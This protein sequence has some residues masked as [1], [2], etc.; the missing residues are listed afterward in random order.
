L[1]FVG[2]FAV[3][4][5]ARA[6]AQAFDSETTEILANHHCDAAC[7]SCAALKPRWL[8]RGSVVYMDR[9]TD[10][11][12]ALMQN[13]A[14]LSQQLNADDFDFGWSVGLDVSLM[15]KRW[16]NNGFEFRYLDLGQ[17]DA[18]TF[19]ITN[20][21]SLMLNASPPVF[22][23]NVQSID[24]RYT[25]DL[26]SFEANYH[27]WIS[28]FVTYLAGFRYLGL[29]DDI[30]AQLNADPQTFLYRAS[31]RNDLY[32]FQVGVLGFPPGLL[33][34]CLNTTAFA[35]VGVFGNAAE[36][37]SLLDTG[38]ANLRVDDSVGRTSWAGEIGITSAW[39][40]TACVSVLGGYQMLW[41]ERVA[42]A[43]DQL[44]VSDFFDG[45]GM[46]DR[47]GAIFHG[48]YLGVELLH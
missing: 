42:V 46:N 17:L 1:A 44:M 33:C 38:V 22:V 25:S 24:A 32:G 9:V 18:D 29:D 27:Y 3:V 6:L 8:A 45:V 4:A 5:S 43:S 11:S 30:T 7:V 31:S 35:K 10:D 48:A 41:F 23:P 16:D 37:H 28:D 26:Y 36:H 2:G 47:G 34:G 13:T 14:N 12:R 20:A 39:P 21:A 19:V 15:R 40:V